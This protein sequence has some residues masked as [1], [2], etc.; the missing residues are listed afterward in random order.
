M[1]FLPE[2]RVAGDKLLAMEQKSVRA[3]WSLAFEGTRST[4]A[5][6]FSV[7]VSIFHGFQNHDLQNACELSG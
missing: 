1:C 6:S 3:K 4:E 2:S 7:G 5:G